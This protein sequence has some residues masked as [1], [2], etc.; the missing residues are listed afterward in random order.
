MNKILRKIVRLPWILGTAIVLLWNRTKAGRTLIT[1]TYDLYPPRLPKVFDGIKIVHLTDLHG[2]NF[3][4]EQEEL[5]KRVRVLQPE[6][7]LLTGD[8]YDKEQIP[9]RR[10]E[11]NRLMQ[12]LTEEAPVYASMGN[13]EIRS[14]EL[15]EIDTE[16]RHAGVRLLRDRAA[17]VSRDEAR[18]GICGLD[19][20]PQEKMLE[21][22]EPEVRWE[23]LAHTVARYEAEPVPFKIL[24][25]HKPEL[26]DDYAAFGVDLVFSGHAHGGL[27]EVPLLHKRLLAPGQGVFPHFSQGIYRK[28]RTLLVLSS[29]LGGPRLGLKPEIV[30]VRLHAPNKDL[31][32]KKTL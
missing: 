26:L 1:T 30:C 32:T 15:L 11:I 27:L 6:L 9:E 4:A 14:D 10:Q 18:I 25:A 31:S 7:I 2:R 17:I 29:G 23:R 19:P 24:L 13:H 22:E 16:M 5:I 8:M 12:R 20:N 3:G 21:E 28:D